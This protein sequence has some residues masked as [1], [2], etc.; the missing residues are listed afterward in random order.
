MNVYFSS[1][2]N[3]P[4]FSLLSFSRSSRERQRN[5]VI[6]VHRSFRIKTAEIKLFFFFF[7]I[8]IY[9]FLTH[10]VKWQPGVTTKDHETHLGSSRGRGEINHLMGTGEPAVVSRVDLVIDIAEQIKGHYKF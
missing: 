3:Q 10:H 1:R 8:I 6:H 2:L 7:L 4:L 5:K 9:I